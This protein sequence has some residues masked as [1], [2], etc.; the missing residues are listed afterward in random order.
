MTSTEPG[1]TDWGDSPTPALPAITNSISPRTSAPLPLVSAK[2]LPM[3]SGASLTG[4]G[5]AVMLRN[6]EEAAI[7]A[8]T[9]STELLAFETTS[10]QP[11]T[12]LQRCEKPEPALRI[13]R[14]S[15]KAV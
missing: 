9:G 15:T 11:Y 2:S 8:G 12:S 3:I 13:T 10:K 1:F 6:A 4:S 5:E 7:V 14:S